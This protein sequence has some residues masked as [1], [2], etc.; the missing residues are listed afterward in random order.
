MIVSKAAGK[1][2]VKVQIMVMNPPGCL[3][4]LAGVGREMKEKITIQENAS[5][6]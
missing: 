6:D 5:R 4:I 2:K 1:A 3:G